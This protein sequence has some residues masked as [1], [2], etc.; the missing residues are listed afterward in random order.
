MLSI[1]VIFEINEIL[2]EIR[3]FGSWWLIIRI[4][5]LHFVILVNWQLFWQ[6]TVWEKITFIAL[7]DGMKNF[8]FMRLRNVCSMF[9]FI[10]NDTLVKIRSIGSIAL[11][12]WTLW[13]A[14]QASSKIEN[15]AINTG[16][17]GQVVS[18]F[19]A[20]T[21]LE[22]VCQFSWTYPCFPCNSACADLLFYL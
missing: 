2:I 4:R 12:T 16:K 18:N 8:L 10:F 11:I 15:C 3:K 13:V 5:C 1:Y 7:K 22:L 20:M 6:L 14:V 21:L 9:Y 17:V 19:A